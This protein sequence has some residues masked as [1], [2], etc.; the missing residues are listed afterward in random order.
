MLQNLPLWVPL[1]TSTRMSHTPCL[2]EDQKYISLSPEEVEY[3]VFHLGQS[4]QQKAFWRC[5]TCLLLCLPGKMEML[6]LCCSS[7][8][9]HLTGTLDYQRVHWWGW[10]MRTWVL[11]FNCISTPL[12]SANTVGK[13]DLE[14]TK[15]AEPGTESKGEIHAGGKLQTIS[16]KLISFKC[17][18][19]G[20]FSSLLP[21]HWAVYLLLFLTVP[22][23]ARLYINGRKIDSSIVLPV[24]L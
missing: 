15:G 11:W 8:G 13:K 14:Q 5:H 19:F 17:C 4:T 7:N 22:A 2:H 21:F 20:V 18:W 1:W 9:K 10:W 12:C 23:C 6:L 16:F 3:L 24:L